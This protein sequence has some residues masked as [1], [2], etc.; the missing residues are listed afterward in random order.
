MCPLLKTKQNTK[1]KEER[2][3]VNIQK[4]NSCFFG[5]HTSIPLLFSE[6]IFDEYCSKD[7]HTLTHNGHRRQIPETQTL[8]IYLEKE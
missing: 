3:N 7:T 4:K 5:V 1:K 6:Q 8:I 2:M